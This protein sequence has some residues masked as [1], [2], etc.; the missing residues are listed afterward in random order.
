MVRNEESNIDHLANK[1]FRWYRKQKRRFKYLKKGKNIKGLFKYKSLKTNYFT[2]LSDNASF[3]IDYKGSI[4]YINV[5]FIRDLGYHI[6][7]SLPTRGIELIERLVH[8]EDKQATKL[9]FDDALKGKIIIHLE[10][11][12]LCKNGSYKHYS[13]VGVPWIRKGL[14]CMFARDITERKEIEEQLRKS[15]QIINSILDRIID[16][17]YAFDKNFR[18]T[19][20]NREAE[21]MTGKNRDQLLGKYALD[22]FPKWNGTKLWQEYN[23]AIK[24]KIPVHFESQDIYAGSNKWFEIHAYPSCDGLTVYFRNVTELKQ[25][26][27]EMEHLSRLEL[28]AQ[29]AAGISHEIRNPITSIRGFLQ[30]LSMKEQCRQFQG[31]FKIMIEEV[32]RCNSIITEFLSLT[33]NKPEN[34]EKK[35]LNELIG[36][37]YPLI[38][39][40]VIKNNM[41][42]SLEQNDIPCLLIN[43][44]E[45]RQLILNMVRN[46]IEAMSSGGHLVIRTYQEAEKIVLSIEDQGKGIKPELIEKIGTPFFTTK[47][48][49]TG[50]G[51]ASCYSI[52]SRHNATIDFLTSSAGTKFFI[53]FNKD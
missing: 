45:I 36:K 22:V 32:D 39:S 21:L 17:F 34:L 20:V 1:L 53:T 3:I 33:H 42:I 28:I 2:N 11:R 24:E 15:S 38:L 6:S 43:E 23:R 47:P 10:N 18:F 29:M 19:Y 44:K 35:N 41:N 13:W 40:D 51:L 31:Y 7:N 5:K 9:C 4:R 8:P 37:I 12:Y 30:L 46:G 26:R 48:E 25:Y 14:I 16:G 49:G 27:K 50:L 52:A